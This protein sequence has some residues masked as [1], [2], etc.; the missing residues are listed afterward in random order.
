MEMEGERPN[1]SVDIIDI[2]F[3]G[4][5]GG[6]RGPRTETVVSSVNGGAHL[7]VY[8]SDSQCAVMR[9]WEHGADILVQ[10]KDGQPF[11]LRLRKAKGQ[12]LTLRKKGKSG[13]HEHYA[14]PTAIIGRAAATIK[15][16]IVES[17][18]EGVEICIRIA[19]FFN[20]EK[21]Q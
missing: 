11:I 17:W 21:S 15:G 20:E 12:G 6:G 2:P 14:V 5:G 10:L 9:E 16:R 4:S 1:A 19:G 7:N 18:S 13:W 3:R 8:P